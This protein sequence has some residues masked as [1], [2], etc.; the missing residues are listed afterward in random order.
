MLVSVTHLVS[1]I[2]VSIFSLFLAMQRGMHDE[3]VGNYFLRALP[4][5]L[6][7][8]REASSGTKEYDNG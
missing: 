4:E 1:L 3:L 8:A 7:L 2:F 5:R 6:E